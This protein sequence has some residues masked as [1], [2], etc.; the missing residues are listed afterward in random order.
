MKIYTRTGDSGET[1]FLGPGRL[2]KDDVRMQAGGDVD[3]LNAVLGCCLAADLAPEVAAT[4]RQT[5]HD[6]FRLGAA[7]SAAGPA[8]STV[9]EW[10][11][12]QDIRRLENEI[13]SLSGALPALTQFVLPGGD[14]GAALLHLARTVCRRAERSLVALARETGLDAGCLAFLNRLSDYLFVAAR[15][16]NQHAEAG[17]TVWDRTKAEPKG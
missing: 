16:Q 5:Q 4:L 1:G 12:E 6:L 14:A 11:A 17:E 2:P 8:G 9:V 15:A 3:E 10:L 7:I 13:D